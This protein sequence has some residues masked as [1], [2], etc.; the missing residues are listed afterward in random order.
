LE[1]DGCWSCRIHQASRA[2]H[3]AAWISSSA[4]ATRKVGRSR[5]S[6]WNTRG[7]VPQRAEAAEPCFR[8]RPTMSFL[9]ERQRR[10][11]IILG[12]YLSI[13]VVRKGSS[14]NLRR[15]LC[16]MKLLRMVS[17]FWMVCIKGFPS[18]LLKSTPLCHEITWHDSYSNF[19]RVNALQDLL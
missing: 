6:T 5:W 12:D 8:R 10:L 2:Y 7:S 18:S 16:V 11:L 15:N 14:W 1:P 4:T 13:C 3:S 17:L 9:D 19:T